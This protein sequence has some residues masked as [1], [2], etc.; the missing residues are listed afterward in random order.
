[1][2]KAGKKNKTTRVLLADDHEVV[3]EAV[4]HALSGDSTL[5]VVG[6][7]SDGAEAV[8]LARKFKPELIIIDVSMP[9]MDGVEAFK[10]IRQSQPDVR[11]IVFS[12]HDEKKDI[13]SLFEAG[14]SGYVLKQEP[15]DNL[16][17]AIDAVQRGGTYYSIEV[18]R[19][20]NEHMRELELGNGKNV[21]DVEDG[22]AKLSFREK[23]VF[24]L[25][26][27]GL[28]VKEIASRLCI[29]PKTVE[30]HKYNIMEKLSLHSTAQFTKIA[31]R[32]GL[33]KI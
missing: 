22:I 10:E 5:E 28:T 11:V 3:L 19:I 31:A 27:E 18:H 16:F 1:M 17:M 13:A 12:M 15:L 29:S 8:R 26:A 9:D 30:S 14:I 33:I 7:A 4:R 6:I 32:K 2:A 20:L 25:L 23:E 21:M 24:P